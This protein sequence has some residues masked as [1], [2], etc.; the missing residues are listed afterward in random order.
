MEDILNA[1]SGAFI[2]IILLIVI[3][4]FI[5]R[6]LRCWYWKV[7][8]QVKTLEAIEQSLK[9]IQKL[10]AQGNTV[11]AVM[12]G[13]ISNIAAGINSEASNNNLDDE[14]PEL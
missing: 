10:L 1:G 4:W 3:I 12:T 11:S 6:E 13:E 9:D 8:M 7:N 2:F 5:T 14:L